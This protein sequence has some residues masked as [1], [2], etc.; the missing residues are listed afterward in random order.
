MGD[1]TKNHEV[2]ETIEAGKDEEVIANNSGVDS[3]S[4][5]QETVDGVDSSSTNND[6]EVRFNLYCS[7]MSK[8][9]VNETHRKWEH[10]N[11]GKMKVMVE[12]AKV[13]QVGNLKQCD[14]CA[15]A[16]VKCNSIAKVTETKANKAG[17]RIFIDT[18]EPFPTFFGGNRY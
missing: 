10:P 11:E 8:L 5:D 12:K 3:S 2:N 14:A 16:K 4:N 1:L 15:V 9:D 17:E 7:S 18:S 6:K 13:T